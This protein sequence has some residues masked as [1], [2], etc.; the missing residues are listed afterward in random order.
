M[1]REEIRNKVLELLKTQVAL[2]Q[3]QPHKLQQFQLGRFYDLFPYEQNVPQWQTEQLHSIAREI[4]QELEN[5]GFIYEGTHSMGSGMSSYPYYTITEYG[6]E[7]LLKD[8]W[9]PYDPDGYLKALKLRVPAMDDITLTYI[10]EA[11]SAY[12]RHHLLSA[13][14]TLGVASENL[15]L[16][17]IETYANW[18]PDAVRKQ[19][20]QNRIEGKFISKQ[21]KEFKQE[22]LIDVR[23]LSK[24]TQANWETYLDGIFN[25]IRLNRN[26]AGHPTGKQFDAKIVY[27]NLQVFSE[28]SQFIFKLQSEF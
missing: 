5:S 21:Y 13:T 28:Y 3:A 23:S 8:D 16:T 19:N 26:D 14:I 9:L 1:T 10:G 6:K 24:D 17:L 15:M 25:F 7:A 12:N 4:I 22:F 18:I 11:V 27:A 2:I 20:F